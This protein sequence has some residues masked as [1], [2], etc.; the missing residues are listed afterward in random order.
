[1]S[2]GGHVRIA[3]LGFGFRICLS[4]TSNS[5]VPLQIGRPCGPSGLSGGVATIAA[6]QNQV[7]LTISGGIKCWGSNNYGQLGDGTTAPQRL[8]PVNVFGFASNV[9]A[10]TAVGS[11]TCAMT[12]TGWSEVLGL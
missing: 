8:T 4:L 7:V 10:I 3:P 5:S 2:A 6:G 1:M 11:H 12:S 9:T